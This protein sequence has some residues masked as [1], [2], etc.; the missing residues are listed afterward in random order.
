MV[1]PLV[2]SLGML[3]LRYHAELNNNEQ[4]RVDN[5][6]ALP[7]PR[8]LLSTDAPTVRPT[9]RPRSKAHKLTVTK[10]PVVLVLVPSDSWCRLIYS[11]SYQIN[12]DIWSSMNS[13]CICVHWF[14]IGYQTCVGVH[15]C[16]VRVRCVVRWCCICVHWCCINVAFV[17]F[18]NMRTLE[19]DL[20]YFLRIWRGIGTRQ[21]NAQTAFLLRL[22]H[23]FALP[24]GLYTYM[25]LVGYRIDS[26]DSSKYP[27][28]DMSKY[29]TS[30]VSKY[31]TFE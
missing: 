22:A 6:H 27:T 18:C 5:L 8:E 16:C 26:L 1:Y 28:F 24:C 3:V 30:D 10:Y 11:H 15:W 12:G 4:I 17:L 14:C 19:V 2:N 21:D 20:T 29:R 7:P 25:I 31:R 9:D 23:F 13:V